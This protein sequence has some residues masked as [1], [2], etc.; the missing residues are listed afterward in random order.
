MKVGIFF[1]RKGYVVEVEVFSDL[2]IG[3]EIGSVRERGKEIGR[4]SGNVNEI[5]IDIMYVNVVGIECGKGIWI[6]SEIS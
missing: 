3:V 5:V 6:E 2:R 4:G 1:L